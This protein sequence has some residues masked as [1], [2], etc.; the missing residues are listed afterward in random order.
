MAIWDGKLFFI[1][2]AGL[3]G[4]A[5]LKA[6][7]KNGGKAK[8]YSDVGGEFTAPPERDY[9]GAVISPG[10][11]P[12]HPVYKYCIEHGITAMSEVDIGFSLVSARKT[13]GIT[14]TNGKTTTTRLVADMLGGV[15]CGNIGYPV[16]TAA[17]KAGGPIVCE[18]S[19]FQLHTA[20]ISPDVAVI[21]NIA[22]DHVDWHGGLDD[23]YKSKCNVA[24]NMTDGFLVL[25]EDISLAA[26]DGLNT[27]ARI[28]RCS[29]HGICDGA[30]THDGYF[31]FEGK[32]V[33]PIDYLRLPGAHNIKNALCAI[34]AAKCLGASNTAVLSA[35]STAEL[36]PHRVQ[37]IGVFGGKT[38][39]D[40]SKG[41][42]VSACLA[43]ISETS[44]NV[45]LILGGRGKDTDFAE[46]FT[47]LDG[48]V[49]EIIAMGE[50]AQDIRNSCAEH[51]PTLK[52]TV[53]NGLKDAVRV[54]AKSDAPTVLLSPACASFDEF[55]SYA[56]RGERF[57]AEVQALY[58]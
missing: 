45:C 42:N 26:L 15:A 12:A 2:G 44:G 53:V 8:I 36:S 24:N 18:L 6:I 50:T 51:T 57:K 56:Q 47:C 34:A 37:R 31:M 49:T 27:G 14:G 19:S 3:S 58:R 7:K 55:D 54:A 5:A 29:T 48:R 40:D 21:T 20:R 46:L 32:R 30:Y 11:K 52:I 41:T 38:W 28:V 9:F 13:V 4:R 22:S 33:C 1:S 16:S 17:L 43:A 10:I 23:Y 39:V 25:G 35:L